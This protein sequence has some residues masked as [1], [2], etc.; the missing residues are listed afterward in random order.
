[1]D[2]LRLGSQYGEAKIFFPV[3]LLEPVKR[4]GETQC[5]ELS[6]S[7]LLVSTDINDEAAGVLT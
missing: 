5:C 7:N 3:L 1:M 2:Q 6:H 4:A